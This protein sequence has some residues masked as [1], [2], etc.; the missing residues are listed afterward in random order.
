METTKNSKI[1]WIIPLILL[2][3]LL[4]PFLVSSQEKTD[5]VFFYGKGCPHCEQL[6]S[7]LDQIKDKYP[8]LSIISYEVYFNDENRQLFGE[9]AKLYNTEIQG[10]PT[11]FIN[12]KVIVGFS[13]SISVS[14]EQELEKCT[15]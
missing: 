9:M 6:E 14:I 1:K 13:N 10:V 11:L 12:D 15:T 3:L 4:V 2:L 8:R 5:L 7:F